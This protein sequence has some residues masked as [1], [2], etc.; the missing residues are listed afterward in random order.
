M[1]PYSAINKKAKRDPPY[2]TLNP[3]TSSLSPSAKSKGARFVSARAVINH[4]TKM[5]GKTKIRGNMDISCKSKVHVTRHKHIRMI[6]IEI[7]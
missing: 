2:S 5:L 7:S 1:F 4:I 3:E 6:A